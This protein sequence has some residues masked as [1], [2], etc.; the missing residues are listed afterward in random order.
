MDS[1]IC[2][3][4]INKKKEGNLWMYWLVR[5]SLTPWSLNCPH[6]GCEVTKNDFC[7][8]SHRK[9]FEPPLLPLSREATHLLFML[10]STTGRHLHVLLVRDCRRFIKSLL[11]STCERCL[12]EW[13]LEEAG[14]E[15]VQR[16]GR[17]WADNGSLRR[18][19][20]AAACLCS[21]KNYETALNVPK[22]Q[23]QI[24]TGK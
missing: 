8:V 16:V 18:G 4:H 12:K 13:E 22:A 1:K 5:T 2:F 14:L 23:W 20:A 21:H 19:K 11:R 3:C 6:L 7:L 24:Q 15:V 17:G 10:G 9:Y